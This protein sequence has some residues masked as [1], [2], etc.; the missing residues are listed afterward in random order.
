MTTTPPLTRDT[1]PSVV[2]VD[3][4]TLFRQGLA[5]LLSAAGVTVTA[6]LST[7]AALDAVIRQT[8]TD[9]V[10]LDV[11]M[12]PTHTDEGLTA[13]INLRRKHPTV[14]ALVLSTYTESAWASRLLTEGSPAVGY[15]LKDRVGD[16]TALVDAI[17]R[18]RQGETVL[19][20]EV[21]K[22]LI[23]RNRAVG[24]LSTLTARE[25][26]VLGLMA[27]GFS[28]VGISRRLQLSPKTVE[29]HVAAIFTKLPLNGEDNTF[30]RRVLAVLA[31]L[32]E[33]EHH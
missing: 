31:F 7:P 10:I 18:I 4:S 15:L 22:P 16:V 6:E 33:S 20:P 13:A 28:T 24:G 8:Q 29:T 26:E 25:R 30:N 1:L 5:R 14:G 23:V 27:E 12:P 21:V 32:R 9:V 17:Q 2:L 3:D 19:D 11:R